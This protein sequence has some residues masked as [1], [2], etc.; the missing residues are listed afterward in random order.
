MLH[1]C[2]CFSDV[3]FSEKDQHARHLQHLEEEM[4]TQVQKVE[5]RVRT[6]VTLSSLF[7][8]CLT[9]NCSELPSDRFH[10]CP[11]IRVSK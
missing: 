11:H 9:P 3:N 10:F 6:E 8:L 7:D 1:D 2:V 4:E 5:Q